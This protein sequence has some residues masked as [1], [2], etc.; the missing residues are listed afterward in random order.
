MATED[1]G[2]PSLPGEAGLQSGSRGLTSAEARE[3][4]QEYG[5]NELPEPPLPGLHIIFLRQFLSPFIYIL[6]VAAIVSWALNQMA[7]AVFIMAVLLLNAVI[8][9]VQEFSAQRSAAALRNMVR[10]VAHVIRDG[11]A[12]RIDVEELGQA[13]RH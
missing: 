10:G 11:V 8:G 13:D 3:R 7:N 9:T 6:L 12:G 1:G 5:R 4:L 2:Q